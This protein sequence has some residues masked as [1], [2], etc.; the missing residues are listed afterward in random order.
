MRLLLRT[1][2]KHL[3]KIGEVVEVADGYARNFL[4]PRELAIVATPENEKKIVAERRRSEKREL[5]RQK[6]LTEAAEYLDGKSVTVQARATEDETLYGSVG[7]AEICAALRSE[8]NVEVEEANVGLDEPY[9]ALGVYEVPM[10]FGE[11]ET[12]IKL[13]IVEE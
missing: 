10:R 2:V 4:L 1:N 12:K 13:W 8:H 6:S 5:E 11:I 3:G 9:K 7:P